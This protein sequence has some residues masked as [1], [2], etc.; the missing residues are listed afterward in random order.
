[1]GHLF[2]LDLATCPLEGAEAWLPAV[3]A[4]GN[5]KDPAKIAEDLAEKKASQIE[6]MG[7]DPDLSRISALGLINIT[8]G[9][10]AVPLVEVAKDEAA[11]KALLEHYRR[12]LQDADTIT[13]NGRAFDLPLIERRLLYHGLRPL[14]WDLNKYRTNHIDLLERLS[15]GD[16]NRRRSLSFYV[17]R[18]GWTD[19]TKTLSGA[20]EAQAPAKGQWLEL[21][22]SVRHDLVATWRLA[23]WMRVI[24]PAENPDERPASDLLTVDTIDPVDVI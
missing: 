13:Y 1:M 5:L 10:P 20:E 24:G 11:E 17:K 15:G 19:L 12:D 22:E 14:R 4:R 2:I 6:L 8:L 21:A 3:K 16:P 23:A 9:G 18:L 7:L